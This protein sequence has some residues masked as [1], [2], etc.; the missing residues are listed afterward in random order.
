MSEER[1]DPL[2]PDER[3]ARMQKMF[4]EERAVPAED[5]AYFTHIE[6]LLPDVAIRPNTVEHMSARASERPGLRQN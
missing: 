2:T 4:N 1:T 6:S 5:Y 3:L